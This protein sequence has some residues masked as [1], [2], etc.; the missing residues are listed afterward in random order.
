MK[1][2]TLKFA[3]KPAM[4]KFMKYIHIP[5]CRYS[6]EKQSVSFENDETYVKIATDIFNAE[7]VEKKTP[8]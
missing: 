6:H 8:K 3:D 4:E 5:K 2:V 7:L 1:E